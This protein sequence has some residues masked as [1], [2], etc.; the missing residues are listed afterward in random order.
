[1]RMDVHRKASCETFSSAMKTPAAR[2]EPLRILLVENHADTRRYLRMYLED[3]G[4]VVRETQNVADTVRAMG[5]AR[6]DV[7]ICDVGLP[8][9]DGWELLTRLRQAALEPRYA[10]AMTGFGQAGDRARSKTAGFRHHLLKPFEPDELDACLAEAA[11]ESTRKR[12]SAPK[13]RRRTKTPA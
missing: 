4:H 3:S 12:S 9:G 13:S 7:L 8:D 2:A 5:E 11:R 1:M 10:I 6:S